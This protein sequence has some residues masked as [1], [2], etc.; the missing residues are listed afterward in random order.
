MI[1]QVSP[2]WLQISPTR[3]YLY[4]NSSEPILFVNCHVFELIISIWRFLLDRCMC[5][6]CHSCFTHLSL[7]LRKIDIFSE[8]CGKKSFFYFVFIFSRTSLLYTNQ[9]LFPTGIFLQPYITCQDL[10]QLIVLKQK[11]F[12]D[13]PE[14]W[15]HLKSKLT[16][17]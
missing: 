3:K 15:L 11:I 12:S 17:F 9:S 7:C 8:I 13:Y 4:Y 6:W 1:K 10:F 14:M 16:P 5:V 2:R